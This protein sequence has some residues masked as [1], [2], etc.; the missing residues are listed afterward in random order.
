METKKIKIIIP[1]EV[2]SQWLRAHSSEISRIIMKEHCLQSDKTMNLSEQKSKGVTM[3]RHILLDEKVI[4]DGIKSKLRI[5]LPKT[6]NTLLVDKFYVE[7]LRKSLSEV[8]IDHF[9]ALKY[10]KRGLLMFP[11]ISERKV[12]LIDI[13]DLKSSWLI[14][15][16]VRK[17]FGSTEFE[18]RLQY[19]IP[20]KYMKSFDISSNIE[21]VFGEEKEIEEKQAVRREKSYKLF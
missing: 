2:T 6:V 19:D 15:K 12:F 21:F 11:V 9:P 5:F 3:F 8:E 4:I 18:D 16:S 20:L 7:D 1:D 13:D 14:N 10:R 17:N